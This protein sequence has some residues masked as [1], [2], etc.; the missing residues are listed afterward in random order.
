VGLFLLIKIIMGQYYKAIFLNYKTKKPQIVFEPHS[1]SNG[2]K[3]MEHAYIRNAMVQYAE[4]MLES[5]PQYLVWAGDYADH[6]EG[7]DNNLYDLSERQTL[8]LCPEDFKYKWLDLRKDNKYLINYTKKEF[9]NKKRASRDEDGN[10]SF[11]HPLALITADGNG[12]GGGDYSGND[13]HLVG[14]WAKDLIGVA[15]TKT[16]IPTG[17]KELYVRFYEENY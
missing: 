4:A 2:A 11:I 9:I 16:D 12:R 5:K 17:F 7:L 14:H 8:N 6:E 10:K 15:R 3:L 13:E 1:W